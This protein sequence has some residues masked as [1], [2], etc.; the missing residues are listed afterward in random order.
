MAKDWTTVKWMIVTGGA[1][2]AWSLALEY[3]LGES[4]PI[5]IARW[6]GVAVITALAVRA[7]NKAL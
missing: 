5:T 7:F 6:A 3:A 2:G 4:P 1:C